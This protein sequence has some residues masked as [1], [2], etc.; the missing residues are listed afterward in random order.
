VLGTEDFGTGTT[1][2]SDPYVTNLSYQATGPL[3]TDGS[4]RIADSTNQKPEWQ[5]SGDHT[6]N[7]HGKML[8]VNGIAETFYNRTVT[9]TQGFVPGDYTI[10]LYFMNIDTI[11]VCAPTPLLTTLTFTVEYLSQSNT[12]VPLGGSPFSSSAFPQTAKPTWVNVGSTYTMPSVGSFIPKTIRV[13]ISDGVVGGCGNDFAIDDMKLAFCPSGGPAPVEFM[14]FTA[15]QKGTGV[16]LNWSTAQEINNSYFEVQ[17]SADGNTNWEAIANVTGAGNSQVVKN[18]STF[19][20]SPL[21]GINYYRIK[22]VDF[23]GNFKYSTIVS[24]KTNI[25]NTRISVLANPFFNTLTVNFNSPSAQ[26]V[27]ARLIDITGKQVALET[28]S[29]SSGN[30]RKDFSNISGLQQGIYILSIR[31]KAGEILFNGKVI[32]Q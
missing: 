30:S 16:S 25:N 7:L 10:S 8:V 32:K 15:Q 28:W 26:L 29:V 20:A 18:Y 19:D 2:S 23:D 3:A 5:V 9:L 12:W 24:V 17:R 22:Q 13:K 14:D 31:N 27:S 11:G 21:S 1:A 6:G 4:Y